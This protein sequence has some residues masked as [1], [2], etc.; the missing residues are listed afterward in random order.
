[1]MS[2]RIRLSLVILVGLGWLFNLIVP[3]FVESYENNLA[4]NGPL[5]LILGALFT[6]RKKQNDREREAGEDQ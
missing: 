5:L 4:A 3:A 1:M 2:D 6:D